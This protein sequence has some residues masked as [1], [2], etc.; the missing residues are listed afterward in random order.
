MVAVAEF[1]THIT[2]YKTLTVCMSIYVCVCV[3]LN[4]TGFTVSIVSI[5]N[6]ACVY[7]Q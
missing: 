3:K 6:D 7:D 5:V 4:K 1:Y 2:K